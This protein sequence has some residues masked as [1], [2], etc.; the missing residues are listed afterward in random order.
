MKHHSRTLILLLC[1]SLLLVPSVSASD[2]DAIADIE[3][4]VAAMEQAVLDGD[5]EAY[6]AHVDLTTDP[7]FA[8]EHIMWVEDWETSG[9]L[10]DF[11]LTVEDIAVNADSEDTANANFTMTW[12]NTDF[13]ERTAEYPVQFRLVDDEWLY[14]G[15]YWLNFEADHFVIKVMPGMEAGAEELLPLLPDIYEHVTTSLDYEPTVKNEIKLYPSAEALVANVWL[16]LPPIR[17]WNEPAEAIKFYYTPGDP[18]NQSVVAHEFTHF[19]SFD[20]AG[21]NSYSR[22]PWWLEEGLA[23]LMGSEFWTEADREEY[24]QRS[25]DWLE[26]DELADWASMSDFNETPFDL[27]RFVYPQGYAFSLFITEEFGEE[28]RNEWLDAMAVE[29]DIEEASESVLGLTFDELD[30]QFVEWLAAVP[31]Q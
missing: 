11:S 16:S 24:L 20:Q 21:G 17:G 22:R 1:L 15:E 27:W 2:D 12:L 13:E 5:G 19:L 30:A 10:E 31:V 18:R 6:L 14:G 9:T 7:L 29:M 8:Q 23:Q 25:R 4:V 26:T 28:L 3:A